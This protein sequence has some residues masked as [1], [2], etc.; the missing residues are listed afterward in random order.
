MERMEVLFVRWFG[1]DTEWQ[2]GWETRRLDRIGFVPE[3]DEGAF[4]FVDPASVLRGCHLLPTFHLGRTSQLLRVSRIARRKNE[5][6]DWDR[7]YV[8][9]QVFYRDIYGCV[10]CLLTFCV[11]L[12][13]FLS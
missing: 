8:N 12:V 9:R 11:M 4:G 1:D 3:S 13:F 10:A 7:F 6:D 5:V 2:S